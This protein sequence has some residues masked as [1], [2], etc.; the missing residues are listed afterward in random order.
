MTSIIIYFEKKTFLWYP[1]FSQLW[2]NVRAGK[3]QLYLHL[4]YLD[5]KISLHL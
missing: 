1:S 3:S 4:L 2:N 5:I